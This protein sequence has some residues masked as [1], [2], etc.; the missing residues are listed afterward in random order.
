MMKEN[1]NVLEQIVYDITG[2]KPT[3]E[4][5]VEKAGPVVND[6]R[7]D[8]LKHDRREIEEFPQRKFLHFARESGTMMVTL[9][10][11]ADYPAKGIRVPYLF[12]HADREQILRDKRSS[13]K[14]ALDHEGYSKAINYFNGSRV[15]KVSAEKAWS[16]VNNYVDGILAGWN[17][18]NNYRY[19][20]G[21]H[22]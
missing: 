12:G 2:E 9:G 1:R 8:L 4:Q 11:Q 3:F 18:R 7:G 6:Y 14:Y 15:V 17:K 5:L 20:G 21:S 19:D 10:D 13:V 22:V 16:L